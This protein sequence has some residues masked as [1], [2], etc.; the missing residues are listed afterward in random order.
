MLK[1]TENETDLVK[2]MWS[3]LKTHLPG[4]ALDVN[5]K[6]SLLPGLVHESQ[7]NN[8]LFTLLKIKAGNNWHCIGITAGRLIE[9]TAPHV[10][11]LSMK[12]LCLIAE[13]ENAEDIVVDRAYTLRKK[14]SL[15]HKKK[16]QSGC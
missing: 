8:V 15:K 13:V 10:L 2:K 3:L 14:K 4:Y 16:K 5:K 11:K 7:P 12:N 6:D 9:V 1:T